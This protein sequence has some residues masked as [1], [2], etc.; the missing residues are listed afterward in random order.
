MNQTDFLSQSSFDVS[1]ALVVESSAVF[2]SSLPQ[3]LINVSNSTRLSGEWR[4]GF[5][6]SSSS[7]PV[8]GAGA[9]FKPGEEDIVI[10]K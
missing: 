5:E 4:G 8:I 3:P 10:G 6:I 2:E 7:S 9:S 1:S